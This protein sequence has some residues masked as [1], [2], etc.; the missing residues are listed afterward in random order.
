M[1]AVTGLEP[2]EPG[3]FQ[4]HVVIGIQIVEPDD[5]IAPLEQANCRVVADEAGG[6]GEKNPHLDD[7]Y[8]AVLVRSAAKRPLTEAMSIAGTGRSLK[9]CA[10]DGFFGVGIERVD[11]VTL[12]GFAASFGG[13]EPFQGQARWPIPNRRRKPHVRPFAGPA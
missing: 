4:R 8:P 5:L 11:P 1:E 13:R 12:R 7:A 2:R 6:A 9:A 3:L 10:V